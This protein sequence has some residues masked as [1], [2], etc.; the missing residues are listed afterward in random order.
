MSPTSVYSTR[1]SEPSSAAATGPVERPM[2][3]PNGGS[4]ARLHIRVELDLRL[5][6]RDR[7]GERAVGVIGLRHGRAEARH[8]RVADE[9]HDRPVLVEDRAVHLG[10][11]LVERCASALGSVVSAIAE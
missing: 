7:G 3:S 10:A 5:E 8:H 2:P 9:L 4:P 6:H 11:V 1:S